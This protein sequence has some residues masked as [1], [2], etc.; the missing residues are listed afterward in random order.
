M[1]T[2]N[3]TSAKVCVK[4][5]VDVSGQKRFKNSIGQYYC[6]ACS[7]AQKAVDAAASRTAP[8]AMPDAVASRSFGLIST[9]TCPHCWHVFEPAEILWVAQHSE[10]QGDNVLGPEA[11][12]RFLPSRFTLQGQAIDG[13]GSPCQLLACPRC[14]LVIPRSCIE[15]EPLFISIIGGPKSGKSYL[16]AAMTWE[17]R[18]RLPS[19]FAISF[20]DADTVSNR[21]LNEYE[22]TL[23]LPEDPNRL[24][25]IRKT[26]LEGELYDQA[27]L[28][29]QT[30]SF[31]RPFL[32]NVRPT[33]QHAF[34]SQRGKI[35]R[36]MCMYDNAGEHFQPGMDTA[37]SPV[38]Q[39]LAK[40]GVLMFIFDPTQ[41]SRFREQC[42][43]LSQD[44]QL[45]NVRGTQRQETLLVEASLRV[46]LYANLP[47][48]R[49]HN[50]PLVVLVSKSDVWGP[51]LGEDVTSEPILQNGISAGHPVGV[52]DVQ[53]HRAR[54]PQPA[55]SSAAMDA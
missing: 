29:G 44:P 21:I 16:L 50:R 43:S 36:V 5:G 52:V 33:P 38:T 19:D 7:A 18:R 14:H 45:T 32:F 42:R 27:F 55:R 3:T 28:G 39:H 25:A 9:I 4:C 53:R 22:E 35:S 51:M 40:S 48:N 2:L 34:A 54:L 11:P 26:E 8:T 49:K 24:V 41:D 15:V 1:A 12:T 17:L 31:P 13:R 23:F 37:G 6:E 20:G 30:V 47:P 46:R 10:L